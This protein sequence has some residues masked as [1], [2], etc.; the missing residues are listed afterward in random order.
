[1]TAT[2]PVEAARKRI[3]RLARE[4]GWIVTR[5]EDEGVVLLVLIWTG[6]HPQVRMIEV[7]PD[8]QPDDPYLRERVVSS[9]LA[10]PERVTPSQVQ[11]VL[12]LLV[13]IERSRP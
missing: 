9:G 3:C 4:L 5:E 6:P 8:A 2:R 11:R 1:M 7:A 10:I 12:D 13:D